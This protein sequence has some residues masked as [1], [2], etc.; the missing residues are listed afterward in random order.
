MKIIDFIDIQ[1]IINN[2]DNF[3]D[4]I[5]LQKSAFI[6]FSNGIYDVPAPMQF[7]FPSAKSDC[8][9]K[10]AFRRGGSK[11]YIKI[12]N[13]GPFG[14]DG[15]IFVFSVNSGKLDT[16]LCDKGLL[17]TLRTAIAGMIVTEFAPGNIENIGIIGSGNLAA[18][19]HHLAKRKYPQSNILLYAR[20]HQKA[21]SITESVCMDIQELVE[22]CSIIFTATSSIHP[23]IYNIPKQSNKIIIALGSDDAHKSELSPQLFKEA[24][25]VITDSKDQAKKFGDIAR[26]LR[27]G[28]IKLNQVTE[29]GELLT[30]PIHPQHKTIIADFSGIGAQDATISE[31]ILNSGGLWR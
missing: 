7:I 6:D 30:S 31:F 3:D 1:R 12:A 17:T 28:I 5:N 27:L 2:I 10:G 4:L 8:H 9:I 16:I 13:G 18:Q 21:L 11:L 20:N 29:I 19:I 14:C 25:I 23:I 26:A 22:K 24:D 15:A